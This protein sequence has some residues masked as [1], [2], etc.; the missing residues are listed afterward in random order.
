M[1]IKDNQASRASKVSKD[2]LETSVNQDFPS[3]AS[4]VIRGSKVTLA[5]QEFKVIKDFRAF[6]AHKESKGLEVT[7]AIVGGRA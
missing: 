7:V 1:E 3:L 6:K 5:L 2:E 4:Q